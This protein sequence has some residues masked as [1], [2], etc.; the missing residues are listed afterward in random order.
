MKAGG[1]TLQQ[2]QIYNVQI[3]NTISRGKSRP[4]PLSVPSLVGNERKYLKDCIDTGWVASGGPY[5]KLFEE[6]LR[7]YTG[8]RHAAACVNGTAGLQVALRLCGVEP[9][10]EVIVPT[11]TFIAPVNAVRYLGAEPVFM[12]C[13]EYL[14]LD[15]GKLD[16]F[17][18]KECVSTRAGLRNRASGRL[19]KAVVPVHVFGSPCEMEAVLSTARRH[20]LKVVEDATESLGSFHR[21]GRLKGRH[22]GTTGDFGVFSFNGNKIITTGGGGMLVTDD[23]RLA[24][25]AAY[26]TTQAKDDPVRYVHHEVGYNFRLSNLQAAV[27]VAQLERLPGFLESKS[28]NYALYR[29]LFFGLTGARFLGAPPGT[30]SNHWF[31]SLLIERRAF[32]RGRDEVMAALSRQKIESRPLWLLNHLQRPYRACQAYRIE[33]APWFAQRLLNLPCSPALTSAQVRRVAG[34]VA[35]L[36]RR[37]G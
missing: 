12:D 6:R 21:A 22:T 28:R 9:G 18:R 27:G 37:N 32:G 20:G 34:A 31:Y 17:C 29:D 23:A 5:V 13:D 15:A 10:T 11:V 14:N 25:R 33:K 8:S 30:S 26:L 24:R 3:L 36:G 2:L 7:R 16:D 19:V 35:A 4:I 1:L